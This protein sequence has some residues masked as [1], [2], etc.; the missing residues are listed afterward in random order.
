MVALTVDFSVRACS[1]HPIVSA[2]AV[3]RPVTG[4]AH[5]SSVTLQI[6]LMTLLLIVIA[7]VK[8]HRFII[9]ED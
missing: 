4:L 9:A 5:Y 7:Y 2:V 1:R 3:L 8:V 6:F